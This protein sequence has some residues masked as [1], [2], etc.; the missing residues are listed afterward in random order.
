[1]IYPFVNMKRILYVL[2][3]LLLAACNQ[4]LSY[5]Q[6][7]ESGGTTSKVTT[8][9]KTTGTG[10]KKEGAPIRGE[11]T[12]GNVTVRSRPE[13]DA[14]LTLSDYVP[15]RCGPVKKGWYPVSIDID[16]S[17]DE[18]S[19]PLFRKGRKITVNGVAAGTL[20]RDTRL[21][22]A[23]DGKR[24]WAT[25]NG[26]TEQLSIRKGT[27]IETAL[28]KYLEQHSGRSV[29]QMQPFIRNFQL[30]EEKILKPYQQYLNYETGTDDPSPLYRLSLIFQGKQLIGV[31]HARPLTIRG[32]ATKR[33]QRGFIVSFLPGIAPTLRED[34]CRKFNHFITSVD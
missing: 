28:V 9:K 11:R 7:K 8:A 25:V 23:T 16:I 33:L 18:Y 3:F 6:E 10:N 24:M 21:P 14:L 15:L 20:Q 17:R 32:A 2:P 26:Y 22:V 27:V 34:Y 31:L 30:Q 19:K 5:E 1:M 13:G 12:N 4:N 29:D